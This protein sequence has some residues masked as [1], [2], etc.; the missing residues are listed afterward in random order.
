MVSLRQLWLHVI[1][2]ITTGLI[3]V[4]TILAETINQFNGLAI[5]SVFHLSYMGNVLM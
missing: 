4:M 5:I 3:T 2:R 1:S